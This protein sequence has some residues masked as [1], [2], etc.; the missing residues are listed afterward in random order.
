MMCSYS[1]VLK[2]NQA[3]IIT[4]NVVYQ[5]NAVLSVSFGLTFP[6]LVWFGLIRD[7][8]LLVFE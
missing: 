2:S 8:L 7:D 3:H 4:D 1:F 6:S 5:N